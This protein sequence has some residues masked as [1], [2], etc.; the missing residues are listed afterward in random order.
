[1]KAVSRVSLTR[2][3]LTVYTFS[4]RNTSISDFDGFNWF[5]FFVMTSPALE[6]SLLQATE[7]ARMQSIQHATCDTNGSRLE[8]TASALRHGCGRRRRYVT[9]TNVTD[10]LVYC[11]RPHS[12]RVEYHSWQGIITLLVPC[13]CCIAELAVNQ[14]PPFVA[15]VSYVIITEGRLPNDHV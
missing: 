14:Q 7:V 1:L 13:L 6:N 9:G 3:T 4:M 11:G 12:Q 8:T 15:N 10:L 2:L 5:R